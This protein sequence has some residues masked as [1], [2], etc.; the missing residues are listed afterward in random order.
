MAGII[1]IV[2]GLIFGFYLVSNSIPLMAKIQW[3]KW[4]K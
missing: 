2:L 4:V 1:G 3:R